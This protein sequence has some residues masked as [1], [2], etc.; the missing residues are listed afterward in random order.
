M[1]QKILLINLYEYAPTL[2][3]EQ[4]IKLTLKNIQCAAVLLLAMSFRQPQMDGSECDFRV[5]WQIY[6]LSV[7]SRDV[8]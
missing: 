1:I 6:S 7:S 4:K 8:T 5:F 3:T 2:H